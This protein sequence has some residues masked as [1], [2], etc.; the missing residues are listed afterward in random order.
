MHAPCGLHWFL[1]DINP[2]N[3]FPL[4]NM[5]NAHTDFTFALW[6]ILIIEQFGGLWSFGGKHFEHRPVI[7]QC[8]YCVCECVRM[9]VSMCTRKR[10][11]SNMEIHSVCVCVCLNTWTL[12]T[13]SWNETSQWRYAVH[14]IVCI[15]IY[16]HICILNHSC[17]HTHIHTHS[18]DS[19]LG[20]HRRVHSI[21]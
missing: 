19:I 14:S 20:Y 9:C 4:I 2:K 1:T 16:A 5:S 17:I 12:R 21:V 8:V 10:T 3:V 6:P 15:Y 18:R 7:R 11:Y 13:Q